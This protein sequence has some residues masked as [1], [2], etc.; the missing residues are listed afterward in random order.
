MRDVKC[1][2]ADAKSTPKGCEIVD[3]WDIRGVE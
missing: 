3:L 1:M 2:W